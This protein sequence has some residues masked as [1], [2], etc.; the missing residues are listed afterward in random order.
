[1]IGICSSVL[2]KRTL[3]HVNC[4]EH[5]GFGGAIL[6]TP[7]IICMR[8]HK[9]SSETGGH[10]AINMRIFTWTESELLFEQKAPGAV[11]PSLDSEARRV[12]VGLEE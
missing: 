10:G 1:M 9:M 6:H 11:L 5:T 3:G 8:T 7:V 2:P 4:A 12:Y